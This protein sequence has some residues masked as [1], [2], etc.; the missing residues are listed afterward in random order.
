[1]KIRTWILLTVSVLAIA[2]YFI[3]SKWNKITLD[4]GRSNNAIRIKVHVPII[5][6]YMTQIYA[7]DSFIA[8]HWEAVD[9][10]STDDKPFHYS[11]NVTPIDPLNKVV[12]KDLFKKRLNEEQ[13]YKLYIKSVILNNNRSTRQGLLTIGDE[14]KSID[15]NENGIDSLARSWGLDYLIRDNALLKDKI[16]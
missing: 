6:E 13:Y 11:K 7:P 9:D 14:S 12:E 5:E 2:A 4:N 10:I 15:L 8:N 1:M 16:Q 3:F